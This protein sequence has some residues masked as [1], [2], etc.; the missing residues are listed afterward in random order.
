MEPCTSDA[1]LVVTWYQSLEGT[2][3]EERATDSL[4]E[5]GTLGQ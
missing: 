5:V 1:L 2:R 3:I 4:V